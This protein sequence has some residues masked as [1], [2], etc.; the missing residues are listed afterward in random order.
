MSFLDFIY[1]L[2]VLPKGICIVLLN[3]WVG[4]TLVQENMY[5]NYIHVADA[6]MSYEPLKWGHIL[7]AFNITFFV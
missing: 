2:Y 4:S 1:K 7:L 6:S 3:A 5:V